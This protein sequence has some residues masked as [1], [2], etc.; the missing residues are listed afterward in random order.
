MS[1]AKELREKRFTLVNNAQGILRRVTVTA[2]DRAQ[3]DRMMGEADTLKTQ[4]DQA[5]A[6]DNQ[7]QLEREV[8]SGHRSGWDRYGA[9]YE[10][11]T[12]RRYRMA[13]NVYLRSGDVDTTV[14]RRAEYRDTDSQGQF[15]GSQS[16]SY[17]QGAAGGYFVPAGFVYDVDVATKY[18]APLMNG[19]CFRI[20]ETATGAVLPYP[21][22][23]D[24]GNVAAELAE[25]TQASEQPLAMGNIT[26][27]A[28]KYTSKVVRVSLELLQDSAFDL[29]AFLKDQFAIRFG[30]AYERDFT[31]GTGNGGA[32][33]GILTALNTLDLPEVVAAGANPNSGNAGDTGANSIGTQDL[34]TLEHS[35][36]PTYRRG[37]RWMLHDDTVRQLKSLLDKFGRPI[38]LPGI[39]VN[40]P[41]TILGYP[42]TIN[43][44]MPKIG[45][46]A[47]TVLFGNL[48][49]FVIRKVREMSVLRL[50]ERYADYGQIGFIAFSRVDSQLV[51][52]GTHP[53]NQLVMHS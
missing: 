23:N 37:G 28:Y 33:T 34:V 12:E 14:L 35:V 50:V 47:P 29:E 53:I 5:E 11:P 10:S 22:N 15:A 43:Q 27:G 13:Y 17:T 32:P 30:R 44:A 26:F 7:D 42:Y 46:N 31:N 19:D 24:T 16:I 21:T 18:Y 39:A 38:W 51:D 40:S 2:E 45:P 3:F 6:R 52:A 1:L 41:D 49:K 36:D 8:Q 48:Q 25:N 4:I 9:K 20:L